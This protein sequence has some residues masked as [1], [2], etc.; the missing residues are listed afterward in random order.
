MFHCLLECFSFIIFYLILCSSSFQ[1]GGL[2]AWGEGVLCRCA[3]I[4]T[5][6]SSQTKN[7]WWSP[8]MTF[9]LCYLRLVVFKA[10]SGCSQSFLVVFFIVFSRGSVVDLKQGH[11]LQSQN[12]SLHSPVLFIC[13]ERSLP[14]FQCV[15]NISNAF[16]LKQPVLGK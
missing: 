4:A 13:K 5:A 12:S 1:G 14:L 11:L 16:F 2:G 9:R 15:S 8:N 3:T 6:T 7:E 10:F